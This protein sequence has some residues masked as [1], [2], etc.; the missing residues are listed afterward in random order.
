MDFKNKKVTENYEVGAPFHPD[1]APVSTGRFVVSPQ[2]VRCDEP[3]VLK[4]TYVVGEGG[5]ARGGGLQIQTAAQSED[6]N[7]PRFMSVTA[8][9][10]EARFRIVHK[11][12]PRVFITTPKQVR[13]NVNWHAAVLDGAD[14]APGDTIEITLGT[15]AHPLV[16]PQ[17][18]RKFR[19]TRVE[20]VHFIDADGSGRYVRLA[21]SPSIEVLPA[22]GE[23]L[24][25][26]L[27]SIAEPG[28]DLSPRVAVTDRFGNYVETPADVSM[29]GEEGRRRA[30]RV[31]KDAD[32]LRPRVSISEPSLAKRANPV[33]VLRA[34]EYRLYWGDIHFHSNFSVDVM[35]Q[36]IGNTPEECYLYGREVSGL[37]FAALTDHYQP[38]FRTWFPMA[39]RGLRFTEELWERSKETS[40][41][42]NRDGE[43]VT[44]FG[45]EYRTMRGDTNIYFRDRDKAPLI[46]G[47]LDTMRRVWEYC[48]DLPFFTA[49]HLHPYSHQYL[50]FGPWKWDVEVIDRW[51]QMGG[52]YEPV[53]EIFSRHGRYEFYGNRPHISPRR[54]MTEGNS[55]QAHL[56]R[57]HRFGFYAGSDDHWG[58]PGQ[59]GLIAVYAPELT[60]EAVFEAIR[61][62]R[63]YG[64]TNARIIVGFRVNDRFM[65]E[66]CFSEEPT[67][68][69]AE[70]HGTDVLDRVEIIRDG[71]IIHSVSPGKEDVEIEYEDDMPVLGTCFYYVR[72]LQRDE[73]M[74]WSSPVWVTSRQPIED[75]H[76]DLFMA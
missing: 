60:R 30:F 18:R 32:V 26:V 29:G 28:E 63:C 67:R 15:E 54:G 5:I 21:N 9:R 73:H 23:N 17:K 19:D 22:E 24:H 11:G 10:P 6:P 33:K 44:F 64:T 42:F 65:G 41:A 59:D 53:I 45:Y 1:A 75:M 50:T 49:P 61:N 13:A 55:V 12:Y 8:S 36:A 37:D 27:P 68:I 72:V 35:V 56:L 46:P 62:R 38:V 71:R 74:A 14:L 76:R 20:I 52:K 40:D 3:Y 51:R 48:S 70:I 2:S 57:G 39:E 34:P 66:E 16:G 43:F 4:I 31:G 7:G 25:A 58:R 47:Q 69:R